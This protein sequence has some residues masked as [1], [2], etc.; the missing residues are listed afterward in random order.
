MWLEQ[1][2]T[3]IVAFGLSSQAK[4]LLMKQSYYN[5]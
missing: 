3:N 5:F 1:S 4:I 2:S